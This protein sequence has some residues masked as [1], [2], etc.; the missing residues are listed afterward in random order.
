MGDPPDFKDYGRKSPQVGIVKNSPTPPMSRENTPGPSPV[1][2]PPKVYIPEP[3]TKPVTMDLVGLISRGI[4]KLVD[5]KVIGNRNS[6]S[7]FIRPLDNQ[8]PKSRP[9]IPPSPSAAPHLSGIRQPSPQSSLPSRPSSSESSPASSAPSPT[10]TDEGQGTGP[11][12]GETGIK[13]KSR[14]SSLIQAMS[15]KMKK[16]DNALPSPPPVPPPPPAPSHSKQQKVKTEEETQPVNKANKWQLAFNVN[17]ASSQKTQAKFPNKEKA[18]SPFLGNLI[19]QTEDPDDV[20]DGYL[21]SNNIVPGIKILLL[22]DSCFHPATIVSIDANKKYGIRLKYSKTHE[23][24]YYSEQDLILNTV[25]EREAMSSDNLENDMRV[26]TYLNNRLEFLFTGTVIDR[27]PGEIILVAMDSGLGHEEI[28]VDNIRILPNSYPKVLKKE[29]KDVSPMK[30]SIKN[31]YNEQISSSHPHDNAPRTKHKHN[32]LLGYDFVDESD[33]EV[34][35]WDLA[36]NRKNKKLKNSVV[37]LKESEIKQEPEVS[38]EKTSVTNL[39]SNETKDKSKDVSDVIKKLNDLDQIDLNEEETI[40]SEVNNSVETMITA[41]SLEERMRISLLSD[42]LKK[43]SPKKNILQK[44]PWAKSPRLVPE[45]L[46]KEKKRNSKDSIVKRLSMEEIQ[47]KDDNLQNTIDDITSELL[48]ICQE[49]NIDTP[50][51]QQQQEQEQ[52]QQQHVQAQQ[53][54]EQVQ[55]QENQEQY[56]QQAHQH[57]DLEKCPD[58]KVEELPNESTQTNEQTDEPVKGI[59]TVEELIGTAPVGQEPSINEPV[60]EEATAEESEEHDLLTFYSTKSLPQEKLE[61]VNP[62]VDQ[63]ASSKERENS[64]VSFK[65]FIFVDET[66]TDEISEDKSKSE[67][68][69]SKDFMQNKGELENPSL[70][71][72]MSNKEFAVGAYTTE[73]QEQKL[74]KYIPDSNGPAEEEWKIDEEHIDNVCEEQKCKEQTVSVASESE[75]G[76]IEVNKFNSGI[77]PEVMTSDVKTHEDE[78]GK[79]SIAPSELSVS[80]ELSGDESVSIELTPTKEDDEELL[81]EKIFTK[82][83]SRRNIEINDSEEEASIK[84]NPESNL[85]IDRCAIDTESHILQVSFEKVDTDIKSSDK[86]LTD[87]SLNTSG[88]DISSIINSLED[89]DDEIMNKES[90]IM[91]PTVVEQAKSVVSKKSKSPKNVK[92]KGKTPEKGEDPKKNRTIVL[93]SKKGT[94]DNTNTDLHLNNVKTEV[95]EV[96]KSKKKN[97]KKDNKKGENKR[98]V[99]ASG[100]NANIESEEI[101]APVQEVI[102]GDVKKDNEKKEEVIKDDA[103]TDNSKNEEVKSTENDKSNGKI[104][105]GFIYIDPNMPQ[106]W[107]VI[108]TKR[109]NGKPDSY[110]FTPCHIKL[111]SKSEII[112]FVEGLLPSKPVKKPTAI[113]ELPLRDKLKKED[114]DLTRDIDPTIFDSLKVSLA[115]DTK[116]IKKTEKTEEETK[117]DTD[118]SS[119]AEETENKDFSKKVDENKKNTNVKGVIKT[120]KQAKKIEQTDEKKKELSINEKD[121]E[122]KSSEAS[123]KDDKSNLC[124]DIKILDDL[125]ENKE[126]KEETK[127]KE[128]DKKEKAKK[129]KDDQKSGKAKIEDAQM[130][131]EGENT[132]TEEG[133]GKTQEGKLKKEVDKTKKDDDKLMKKSMKDDKKKK[134]EEKIEI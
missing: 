113:S 99:K 11:Q 51:Q 23:V 18:D 133:K 5:K 64:D 75:K 20:E 105:N 53:V 25:L 13:A 109:E 72:G 87:E 57:Q 34:Q 16:P 29:S 127:N 74:E 101:L 46:K 84:E 63:V 37:S 107:Y 50:K 90:T 66:L 67:I 4:D 58:K 110:F 8:G 1:K 76:Y 89:E 88:F 77:I 81:D 69:D 116:D 10:P 82:N 6:H 94:L 7:P 114:L 123:P 117:S 95:K 55:D 91:A 124:T 65:P 102:Q 83:K 31:E 22:R 108:V 28:Q 54:Q 27:K 128:E 97:T 48:S 60:I 56:L 35:A 98:D 40:N 17:S 61:H 2:V 14:L 96:E 70:N 59:L 45:P 43:H 132:N 3:P 93:Q 12:T 44:L 126:V 30:V 73:S 120:K 68:K 125:V 131:K 134:D 15:G 42:V 62:Q 52:H 129:K 19:P 122:S 85:E 38:C 111:R 49:S 92:K 118:N 71:V 32:I 21:N 33:C 9:P 39:Q 80:F 130:K 112:K 78:D 24:L 26:A 104:K 115:K 79:V 100:L 47:P 36:I 106:G 103:P 119:V 121:K 86:D 41:I